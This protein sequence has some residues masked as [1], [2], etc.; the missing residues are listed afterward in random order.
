[1]GNRILFDSCHFSAG[2]VALLLVGHE[3]H[4]I[5]KPTGATLLPGDPAEHLP[6]NH[7]LSHS[8]I[9]F[10]PTESD[11]ALE[12]SSPSRFGNIAELVQQ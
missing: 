12:S 10:W 8:A 4:V 7:E 11:S 6:L 2:A 1:M 5:A 3:D 9:R